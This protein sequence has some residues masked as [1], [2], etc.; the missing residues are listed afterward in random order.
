M[1][2]REIEVR[3][4]EAASEVARY[5]AA[6]N[7]FLRGD[8]N[9]LADWR[10]RKIGGVELITD[11]EALIDQADKGLLPYALYRSFSGGTG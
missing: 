1:G 11:E 8:R 10:E 5:K 9:A 6:V 7:R 4:S 2:P 3:G